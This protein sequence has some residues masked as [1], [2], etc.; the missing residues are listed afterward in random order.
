[1]TGNPPPAPSSGGQKTLWFSVVKM[2]GKIASFFAM[3]NFVGC[4]NKIPSNGGVRGGSPLL[5]P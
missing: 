4:C 2:D 3:T 1:M 5:L